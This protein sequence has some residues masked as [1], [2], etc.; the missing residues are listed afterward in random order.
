MESYHTGYK[1]GVG[2][3][4]GAHVPKFLPPS[5]RPPLLLSWRSWVGTQSPTLV[6]SKQLARRDAHQGLVAAALLR[7]A[8]SLLGR[9]GSIGETKISAPVLSAPATP[10]LRRA[11]VP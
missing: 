8:R 1:F 3:R 9:S 7:V 10:E 6:E 5:C 11:R 2:P 4:N